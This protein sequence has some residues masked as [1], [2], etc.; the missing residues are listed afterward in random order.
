MKKKMIIMFIIMLSILLI[1]PF[2][3]T[4]FAAP[5]EFMGVMILLFFIVNPVAAAVTNSIVGKDIKKL[6]WMTIFFPVMFLLS[7]WL[8]LAEIIMD[9]TFYAVIYLIIGLVFMI[10]SWLIAKPLNKKKN[11]KNKDSS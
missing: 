8:V 11:H 9:L 4:K 10:G 6:W 3:L 7:Y 2:V 5:H 1:M